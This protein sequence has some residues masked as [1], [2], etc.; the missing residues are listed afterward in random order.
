MYCFIA[1]LRC[2]GAAHDRTGRS[3]GE[4]AWDMG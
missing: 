1:A 2:G 3:E 4:G